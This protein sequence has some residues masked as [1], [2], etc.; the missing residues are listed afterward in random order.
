MPGGCLVGGG[1]GGCYSFELI[2]TLIVFKFFPALFED[3][4]IVRDG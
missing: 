4:K 3:R 1:G 2:G